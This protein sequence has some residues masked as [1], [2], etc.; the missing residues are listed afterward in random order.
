[1]CSSPP[2]PISSTADIKHLAFSRH[3]NADLRNFHDISTGVKLKNP[4]RTIP[5][6]IYCIVTYSV[7]TVEFTLLRMEHRLH[8]RRCCHLAVHQG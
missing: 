5:S 6:R 1:M 8:C 7:V 3:Q 4:R 2:Q